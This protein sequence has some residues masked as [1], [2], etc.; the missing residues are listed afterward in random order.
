M[1]LKQL[2][3]DR[4]LTQNDVAIALNVDRSTITKYEAGNTEAS[5]ESL[6]KLA[7]LYDV[8]PNYLLGW[9][10]IGQMQLSEERF[11]GILEDY[12][13]QIYREIMRK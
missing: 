12:G 13:K 9:S 3:L 6:K 5:Y 10:S 4:G 7:V 1:S 11:L 8:D 2:R